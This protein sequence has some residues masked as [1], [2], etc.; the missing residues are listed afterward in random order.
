MKW[1]VL[2]LSA[3]MEVCRIVDEDSN[4][5]VLELDEGIWDGCFEGRSGAVQ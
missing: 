3:G 4:V 2:K 5:Q 1:K